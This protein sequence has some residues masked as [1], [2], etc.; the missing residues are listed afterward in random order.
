MKITFDTDTDDP[1]EMM[2]VLSSLY[3]GVDAA[4]VERAPLDVKVSEAT[5]EAPTP[6]PVTNP[7]PGG[8]PVTWKPF[9]NDDMN[10]LYINNVT[11]EQRTEWRQKSIAF[12]REYFIEYITQDYSIP[13]SVPGIDCA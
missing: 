3:E 10:Y 11:T 6:E 13:F 12:W 5:N 1:Q 7:S 9:A 8:D 4:P 2:T